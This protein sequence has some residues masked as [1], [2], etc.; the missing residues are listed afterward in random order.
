MIIKFNL[1]PK[2]QREEILEKEAFFKK[3]LFLKIYLFLIFLVVFLL[4]ILTYV[5]YT[6][7]NSLKKL[8]ADKEN[9]LQKYKN[10]AKKIKTLEKEEQEV[11]KRIETIID[12]KKLQGQGLERLFLILKEMSNKIILT[13]LKL[14]V[15]KAQVKGL[16]LDVDFLAEYMRRLESQKEQIQ[17][18]NLKGVQ[19]KILSDI[20][21]SEFEIEILY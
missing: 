15:S 3:H 4:G 5:N 20:K 1:L 11:R 14:E 19:Q 18:V 7:F 2:E 10:I 16:S 12:L 6:Q 13:N 17:A 8:K 9:Q 21:F